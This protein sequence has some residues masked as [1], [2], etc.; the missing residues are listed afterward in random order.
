MSTLR[1]TDGSQSSVVY[2]EESFKVAVEHAVAARTAGEEAVRKW[3]EVNP[4][5]RST[6]EKKRVRWVLSQLKKKKA[7]YVDLQQTLPHPAP[8]RAA[9]FDTLASVANS[10]V[11]VDVT[12]SFTTMFPRRQSPQHVTFLRGR[13]WGKS[14]LGGAIQLY[15]SGARNDL[16]ARTSLQAELDKESALP[17]EERFKPR[18]SVLVDWSNVGNP[19]LLPP[20]HHRHLLRRQ[21]L[22]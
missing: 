4:T 9:P 5:E 2:D 10:E 19:V 18:I 15:L 20:L 7:S 11:F 22:R 3:K 12:R 1:P 21:L 6:A 16:F 17:A 8:L 13:R 14:V